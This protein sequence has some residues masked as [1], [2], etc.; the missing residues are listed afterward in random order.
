MPA[1]IHHQIITRQALRSAGISGHQQ[2]IDDYSSFPDDYHRRYQ[3][4]K[5]YMFIMDD[6]EFHYPPHTPVDQFYRYWNHS[7]ERG[8]FM[9]DTTTNRNQIFSE[10][11]FAFYL[12]NILENLKKNAADEADKF[13]GCL[14]HYLEDNAFGIHAL[15][16]PDGTDIYI[17]D[18]LSGTGF[19]RYIC[20]IPLDESLWELTV[21]PHIFTGC[22]AEFP[23]LLYRR[24]CD[25]VAISRQALFDTAADYIYGKSKQSLLE[26]H[27]I[28]FLSAVQLA[29]DTIATINA[30]AKS[31]AASTARR[32]LT[33]FAPFYYPFGGGGGFQLRRY[34][35]N[36]NIISFGIN[37]EARLL[38][39][40]PGDLYRNF[41]ATLSAADAGETRVKLVNH[42]KIIQTL[43]ISG[44]QE[45]PIDIAN[46][47][48]EFGFIVHAPKG[49]G[50]LSL[51][52]PEFGF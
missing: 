3:E 18:R 23:A 33:D 14:L 16:G 21:T 24:Y 50:A 10:A 28:M 27:R 41:Q 48:G 26:N 34:Q 32:K 31:A 49:M 1:R 51:S 38:Y 45:L 40:I 8:T 2:L 5:P 12:T 22:P 20:S 19:A 13:L 36:E 46:P 47:G 43:D 42:G 30:L 25:A 11:G 17:L 7:P 52:D 37:L 6:L 4:V 39:A 44:N 15:E 29:A 35:E 9:V